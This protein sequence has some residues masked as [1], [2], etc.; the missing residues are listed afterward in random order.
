L[1][2]A[3]SGCGDDGTSSEVGDA[4]VAVSDASPTPNAALPGLDAAPPVPEDAAPPALDVAPPTPADAAPPALDAAPPVPE[5]A[6]PP[7]MDAAPLPECPPPFE[8]PAP[9]AGRWSLSM[10]HFNLQY[11]AGGT[12]GFAEIVFGSPEQAGL[13]DYEEDD[14]EDRII[15]ESIV[16]LLGLLERNPDFALTF[17]IQGFAA[18]VLRERHPDTLTRMQALVAAGQLELA[19]I[20]W[21]DQFFLAFPVQDMDRSWALT[22]QSFEAAGLPL[23]PVVFTQEGQFGPGYAAW[24]ARTR[25]GAI[26]V[27]PRNLVRFWQN[28]LDDAPLWNVRGLDVVLPRSIS[29]AFVAKDF[30]FFDDGE[31]LAT[32]DADPYFGMSFV[33]RP[34]AV[35]EYER[36]L[37]CEADRGVRI[38]RVADYVAAVRGAGFTPVDMPPV[39]DGT[40]QPQS[41]RGPLQ[42]MGRAGLWGKHERDD[43]VLRTCLLASHTLRALELAMGTLTPEEAAPY[44]LTRD[45]A[46]RALLLGQVSDARGINPWYGEV[47]Y[48]LEHCGTARDLAYGALQAFVL[49]RGEASMVLRGGPRP[50][51]VRVHSA[52]DDLVEFPPFERLEPGERPL[53][54]EVRIADDGGR[55]PQ[56]STEALLDPAARTLE[57]TVWRVTVEWP[58]SDR[59]FERHAA[60]ID[61]EG[62]DR[63]WACDERARAIELAVPRAA[64]RIGLRPW[65]VT[66]LETYGAEDFVPSNDALE[67]AFWLPVADGW[68]DLGDGLH[69]VFDREAT[70]LAVGFPPAGDAA[71]EVRVRDETLPEWQAGRWVF[72][73]TDDVESAERL[74]NLN[75]W[76]RIDVQP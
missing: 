68:V 2:L 26:G 63:P 40:W 1:A 43:L 13:L 16:P 12:D 19:S 21:S 31:L 76:G 71:S 62:A 56:V 50:E 27:M 32:G 4:T 42:W 9:M 49:A 10:F 44:D 60:C 69:M 6:A 25:P 29:S 39:L 15:E 22:A 23:S 47:Q 34:Q 38:G 30:N 53:P 17:E 66:A 58:A 14:L 37:R 59:A 72:W 3:V 52:T 35:A 7:E 57:T 64:G 65:G 24:L 54:F 73:V 45:E 74:A 33:H 70:Y 18:D 67:D 20:H 51:D 61:R 46:Q 48:G 55:V 5:D 11:V 75:T 36:R 8:G 28:D 41:T